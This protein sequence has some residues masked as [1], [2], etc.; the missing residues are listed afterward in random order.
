MSLHTTALELA[1]GGR[2]VACVPA[3]RLQPGTTTCV[4]GP[5]GC[6]KS[7]LL[8]AL[9]GLLRPSAGQV[10]LDG[11][12]LAA[13]PAK[14]LAR[15]LASLPQAPSAPDGLSVR[16]LV[17]HGRYPHQGLLARRNAADEAQIDWALQATRIAHLQR[18]AFHTLSGGERQRAWLAMTL[19][20]QA[21][22]LLLDEPTTWLDM[23]HQAELLELLA[24]LQHARGLTVVMVLH[25]INHASQYADRLL[26]MRD[27]RI[28][29][30]GAPADIVSA[31]LTHTLFGVRTE[32]VFRDLQGRRIPFCLPL[33]GV[34]APSS[35]SPTPSP[36]PMAQAD[37]A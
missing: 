27:G 9:G 17:G 21:D 7:T 6:G 34:P 19:A 29:A 28:L 30:D 3:L 5:N 8:R 25:D 18:R 22:I 2:T 23:G 24:A 33:P 15:R 12:P 26:A 31:E 35:P 37:D 20:Q 1:H 4:I 10:C 32:Q 16:Q 36:A 11:T 13:W 14:A